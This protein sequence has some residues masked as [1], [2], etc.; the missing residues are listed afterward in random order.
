MGTAKSWTSKPENAWCKYIVPALSNPGWIEDGK[1]IRDSIDL[2]K[3]ELFALIV[4]S[5]VLNSVKGEW[6]VGYDPGDG[7]QQNDG[8]IQSR[9]KKFVV[10]HNVVA[11]MQREEVLE[12]ILAVYEKSADRGV[13]YGKS[14]I[15]VIQPN[16]ESVHSG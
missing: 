13:E 16:K 2:M 14:R 5:H 11:Q 1:P 12:A 6:R 8:N 9:K 7:K 15:L 3:R 10:E 4:L